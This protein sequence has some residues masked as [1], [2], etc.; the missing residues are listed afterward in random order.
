V[1][2]R[3]DV[4]DESAEV[5][6]S[7]DG[8]GNATT[9]DTSTPTASVTSPMDI[10]LP[11]KP[12][13]KPSTPLSV[14]TTVERARIVPTKNKSRGHERVISSAKAKE[15]LWTSAALNGHCSQELYPDLKQSFSKRSKKENKVRPET[16]K[17]AW[18]V[19]EQHLLE[20]LLEEIPDGEK[21]RYVPSSLLPEL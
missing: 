11:S 2:I 16:Y 18:S 5:D 10:G 19:S 1:Y 7:L 15:T 17:Q 8:D 13:S 21:N 14:P 20:R 4:E 9:W 6:I 3:R 12:S